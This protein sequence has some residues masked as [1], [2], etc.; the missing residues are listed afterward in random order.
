MLFGTAPQD[1][2]HYPALYGGTLS[3]VPGS[4][5]QTE[6]HVAVPSVFYRFVVQGL[7]PA[8]TKTSCTFVLGDLS[9]TGCEGKWLEKK[10]DHHDGDKRGNRHQVT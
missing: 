2:G 3:Q 5:L 8:K 10:P 1:L 9:W 7:N 6:L 4:W